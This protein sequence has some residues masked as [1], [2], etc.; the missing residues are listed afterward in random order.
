M[1]AGVWTNWAGN[2]RCS[3]ADVARPSGTDE[4]AAIVKEAVSAGRRVKVVGTG[5]SITDAAGG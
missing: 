2:Q 1:P 5:H 4:L 3:P